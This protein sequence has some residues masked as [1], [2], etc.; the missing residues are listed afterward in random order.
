MGC[1]FALPIHNRG[2]VVVQG[3]SS[4][5][6]GLDPKLDL[7]KLSG[8]W[9][10]E[11]NCSLE[12]YSD[13]IL[14]P[15]CAVFC[16]GKVKI[17]AHVRVATP[18]F[19]AY[20]LTVHR[21]WSTLEILTFFETHGRVHTSGAL[22]LA[23]GGKINSL[24]ITTNGTVTVPDTLVVTNQFSWK[25]GDINLGT[26]TLGPN[27][28]GTIDN[29]DTLDMN[30]AARN[31]INYGKLTLLTGKGFISGGLF[32]NDGSFSVASNGKSKEAWVF[33]ETTTSGFVSAGSVTVPD[34]LTLHMCPH[35]TDY[36]KQMVGGC[37]DT[38]CG[39]PD[40][41]QGTNNNASSSKKA[42]H[43]ALA[44]GLGVGISILVIV[45]VVISI[46]VRRRKAK[47]NK[48]LNFS[49]EDT[50]SRLLGPESDYSGI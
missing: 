29:K 10:I 39:A 30:L 12:F 25:G 38:T 15:D 22:V 42:D 1:E 27:C 37:L 6:L 21:E 44:V 5:K 20:D 31:F 7:Q 49:D 36:G 17:D 26:V 48:Y 50:K 16:N 35:F 4:L 8:R 11:P 45:G 24:E 19:W 47:Q 40:A 23:N 32:V 18:F 43:T 2:D 3:S 34:G 13:F 33:S 46:V 9:F 14:D 28:T 41:C